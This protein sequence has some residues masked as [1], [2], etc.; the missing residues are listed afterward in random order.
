ML[1]M[2]ISRMFSSMN[3]L[4]KQVMHNTDVRM[5]MFSCEMDIHVQILGYTC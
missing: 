4:F 2:L 1:N 3:T 5:N